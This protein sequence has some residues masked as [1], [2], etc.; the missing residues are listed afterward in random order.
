MKF[1]KG[2]FFMKITTSFSPNHSKMESCHLTKVI[3]SPQV[4]TSPRLL[5]AIFFNVES[6]LDVA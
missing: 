2:A 1:P 4:T 6:S 5:A 3:K